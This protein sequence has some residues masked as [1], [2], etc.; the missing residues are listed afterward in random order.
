MQVTHDDEPGPVVCKI[1]D[2]KEA[3]DAEKRKKAQQKEVRKERKVLQSVKTLELNWAI[4]GNDLGHRL[5]KVGG[6]LGEGRKVEIVLAAKKQG[7]KA[8]RAECEGVLGRIR[9]A[10]AEVQGAKEVSME[11]KVGGFV[12]MMLQGKPLPQDKEP[13]DKED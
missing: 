4:D 13:R 8:T 12:T 6:F 5:E 10:V 1:I 7:R 3:F 9:E 11:G 2:K